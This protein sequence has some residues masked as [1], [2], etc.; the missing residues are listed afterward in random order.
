MHPTREFPERRRRS[1]R[2]RFRRTGA[3]GELDHGMVTGNRPELNRPPE[4]LR[5][6]LPAIYDKASDRAHRLLC[7]W[8]GI[9]RPGTASLVHEA[10]CRLSESGIEQCASHE[11]ALALLVEKMRQQL[12]DLAR[13]ID[14]KKRGGRGRDA[15]GRPVIR[16]QLLQDEDVGR[17]EGWDCADFLALDEALG[18]LREFSPRLAQVVE[19][20]FLIGL[21]FKE[22]ASELGVSRMSVHSDWQLAKAWL[23]KELGGTETPSEST[24][25]TES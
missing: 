6:W 24:S 13:R 8:S 19:L 23:F 5:E 18:R 14:A 20:R 21:T 7:R 11:H 9:N 10:F 1:L 22:T 16:R 4:T 12:V 17:Q 25:A 15:S 2:R 3:R